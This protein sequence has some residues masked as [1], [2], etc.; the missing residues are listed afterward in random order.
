MTQQTEPEVVTSL[1]DDE[2]T[3]IVDILRHPEGHFTYAEYH[4][5]QSEEDDWQLVEDEAAKTFKTEF[6]A[7][8]AAT[9]NVEWLMD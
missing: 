3:R 8:T 5:A 7:Y 4:R 1:E 6:A 9:R 2:G